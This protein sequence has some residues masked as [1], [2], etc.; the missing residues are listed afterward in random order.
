MSGWGALLRDC[1]LCALAGFALAGMRIAGTALPL[2]ACLC[3]VLPTGLRPVF[4]AAG[5]AGGY[6][7]FSQGGETAELV[8]AAILMLVSTAVFQGTELP[9]RRWFFPALAGAVAKEGKRAVFA[10]IAEIQRQK[11]RLTGIYHS[12]VNYFTVVDD[13]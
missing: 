7:V 12:E 3:A 8:S 4:A 2:A 1:A 13:R 10:S 5:A 11:V 9:A 6:F